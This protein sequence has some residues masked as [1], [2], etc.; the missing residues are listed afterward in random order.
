MASQKEINELLKQ[1]VAYEKEAKR[2]LEDKTKELMTQQG[3]SEAAAKIEAR[4]NVDFKKQV[5]LVKEI[6]GQIREAKTETKETIGALMQQEKSLKGLSGL[7]ASLVDQDRQRIKL[8][9]EMTGSDAK[10]HEAL[11]SIASL[12]QELLSLSSEDVIAKKDKEKSIADQLEDLEKEGVVSAEILKNLNAQFEKAKGVSSMTEKQQKFLNKQLEVYEGI[13]DTI[14]GVLETAS[15]L[16]STVG[17]VFGSAL[18]GAGYATEAIGKN[19]R[20][21]GGFLG[22]AT[23]SSTLLGL[24]FKDAAQVTKSLSQE[25]GGLNDVTLKTQFNANLMAVNMGIS[26][27]ESA[28]LLGNFSRLNGGSQDVAMN[29][30]QSTKE[31]AQQNGLVPSQIMADVAGSAKAFAEYGKQGGKNIAEAAVAA[32]KLGV[33]MDTLTTVTDSLLDFETSITKEL[34]LG[35]MLGKNI[36]LNRARALAY[37]QNIGGAVKETLKELG[38]IEAFNQMDIFAKRETAALLGL[39]VEQFQKMAMNA[40]KLNKDGSIQQSYWSEVY[41]SIKGIASGP[42]GSILK[43]TGSLVMAG[44]QLGGSFAQMGKEVP[45]LGKIFSKFKDLSSATPSIAETVTQT[46]GGSLKEKATEVIQ[47]KV[48][49]TG[50]TLLD[51]TKDGIS[52]KITGKM[53]DA[54]LP[55]NALPKSSMGDKLKDLAG[56]LKEMG[57]GKVLFGALNLIPTGL[58]FLA[59]LPGIPGMLAVGAFG[60]KAGTGLMNLAIGLGFMGNTSVT[61]GAANLALAGLGFTLMTAGII[62]MAGVALLGTAAGVG[63]S[64]LATGLVALGNPAVAGFAAIGVAILGGLSL[65]MMGLGYALGL[66]A[67]AIEAIGSV[68]LNIFQGIATVIPVATASIISLIDTIT[69]EKVAAI[70]LL[71]LA[72]TGLASSLMF[73]GSA[74]LFALPA[75]LGIAAAATGLSIVANILGIGESSETSAV[76][77]GTLSEYQTN[78]LDKMDKLIEATMKNK[79][80][81]IDG[82]KMTSYVTNK[83]EKLPINNTVGVRNG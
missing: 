74:G 75:L 65:A 30:A 68:V 52:D 71:S 8:Q 70:G 58:G 29:L 48:S 50:E 7:Q 3:L 31:L 44:A 6:R 40:D 53:E 4:K 51:K 47:E 17:G 43:T 62:G 33:N 13:K 39:S 35:A 12:N 41:E 81:Y 14:G 63:L 54:E 38:G 55:D 37:E 34:E 80:I 76:E 66:A 45:G 49:E 32:G 19:V 69:L 23:F 36:N 60:S 1:A 77:E 61:L 24:G 11:N 16:T 27:D 42:L 26:G 18:I 72:F 79:D 21:M 82:T 15:L 64:A 20:E 10:T 57:S 25:M 28:K 56:G 2:L 83:S 9:S 67:P 22:G 78:M 73:L 46:A 5:E 59:I